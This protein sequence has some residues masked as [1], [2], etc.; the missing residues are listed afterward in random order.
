MS[1]SKKGYSLEDAIRSHLHPEAIATSAASDA[2]VGKT[3][4]KV[5]YMSKKDMKEFGWYKSPLVIHLNDRTVFFASSD[6]EGN[7]GGAIFAN[8]PSPEGND[9]EELTFGTILRR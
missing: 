7:N 6:D 8:V 1:Q 9:V 4:V 3:I 5:E 2:L